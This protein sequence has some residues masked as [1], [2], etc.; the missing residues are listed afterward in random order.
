MEAELMLGV[1]DGP[2]PRLDELAR[3]LGQV[4]GFDLNREGS[5]EEMYGGANSL[6]RVWLTFDPADLEPFKTHPYTL[7]IGFLGHPALDQVESLYERLAAIGRYR[8]MMAVD[9]RCIRSTHT[10]CEDY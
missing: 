9:Y 1:L 5:G 6:W 10:L 3:Q 8:I 7:E 4:L 2:V